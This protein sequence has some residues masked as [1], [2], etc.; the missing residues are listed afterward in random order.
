[1]LTFLW[2]GLDENREGFL[3]TD[4]GFYL[5][6]TEYLIYETKLVLVEFM[7]VAL[8]EVMSFASCVKNSVMFGL[9]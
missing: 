5:H 4:D 2:I 7:T 6:V 1:M 9:R 3:L 8:I